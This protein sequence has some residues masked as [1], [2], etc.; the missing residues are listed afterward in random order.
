LGCFSFPWFD[1]FTEQQQ[2]FVT[3]MRA[4]TAYRI[5]QVLSASPY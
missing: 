2:G 5:V 4:K 3:R 1:D